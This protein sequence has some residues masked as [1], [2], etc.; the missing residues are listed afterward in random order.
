MDIKYALLGFLSWRP[1]TGYEL[2]KMMADSIVFYWSGNNNQIYTT[3]V[4]MHKDGLVTNEVQQQGHYP[5]RKVYSI[6]ETGRSELRKWVLSAPETPQLRK[7]FLVQLAW[8]DQ[9]GPEELDELLDKYEYEINM[10]HI[11]LQEQARRGSGANPARTPREEYLW[12]MV[13]ENYIRSYACE[14]EWVKTV[15]DGIKKFN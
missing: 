8:A 14:L 10:Q 5:A 4:Q 7:A 2:K 11:I 15:R 6:T 1:S 3:L 12:K 9:L 13:S